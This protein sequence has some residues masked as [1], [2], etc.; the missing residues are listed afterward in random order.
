MI[1]SYLSRCQ[2]ELL[3]KKIDLMNEIQSNEMSIRENEK[4]ITLIKNSEDKSYTSFTPGNYKNDMDGKKIKE[5][6]MQL[7]DMQ[8]YGVDLRKKLNLIDERIRDLEQIIHEEKDNSEVEY[9]KQKEYEK[10]RQK[11][12]TSIR[13]LRDVLRRLDI[14]S[15]TVEMDP[16]RCKIELKN[17]SSTVQKII[18]D[19]Q[20][21]RNA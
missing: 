14:C 2:Q 8:E 11:Y 19:M 13:Q 4:L 20:L 17:I 3:E 15:K 21:H 12:D 18:N 6:K 5:L 7:S 16:I 10:S 9:L 1:K